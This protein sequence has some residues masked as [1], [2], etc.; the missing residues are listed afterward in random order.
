MLSFLRGPPS[1]RARRAPC[2]A[3]LPTLT[4]IAPIRK[5]AAVADAPI[6]PHSSGASAP[7]T[8]NPM[9]PADAADPYERLAELRRHAP[10]TE[11]IPGVKFAVRHADVSRVFRDW[12]TF[13]NGGGMRLG[14]DKPPEEQTLNEIDPP[15]HGPIRRILLTA[16][17]PA[18]ITQAEP[19]I[20][21]LAR[22]TVAKFASTGRADLVA[23]LAVPLPSTVITHMLGVPE[24]DKDRFHRWTEDMVED[25][26]SSS[27]GERQRLDTEQAFNAYIREQIERRRASADPP[28][29]VITRMMTTELSDGHFLT[30]TEIVTQVRFA[31]MAGNETTTNLISNLCYELI[32]VPERYD[33]VRADRSLVPIAIEESL[34]HDSPVQL[35]FRRAAKETELV[36][37]PIH[38]GD[39]MI[40]S[41]GSANRDEEHY[42]SNAA[43]FDINRGKVTDHMAFGLGPHLCVG[44]PLARLQT[45][46]ALNALL[47]RVTDPRLANDFVYEKVNFFAF[48]GLKHLEVEF[49]RS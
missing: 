15:R 30:D 43:D 39:R 46:H 28:D 12:E 13:S 7:V 44:A 19:Y 35:M 31:L 24:S 21:S 3:N 10:V 16:L 36:G 29:D 11:P 4:T 18:V 17:A 42:G 49:T 27:T 41:M 2:A 8:F 37:C 47:D 40:V 45:S 26:A 34:R 9:D 6:S 32:R 1:G 33:R 14:K 23:E 22:D 38:Q 25:K 48:R 20:E 5:I